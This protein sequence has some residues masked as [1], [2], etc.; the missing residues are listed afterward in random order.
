MIRMVKNKKGFTLMEMVVATALFLIAVTASIGIFLS[1]VKANNKVN[2]MQEV[3]NEARYVI[4]TIAKKIRLGTIYYDYYEEAY[5]VNFEN[6]VSILA[7]ADNADNV[8]Y[9]ALNGD[10]ES[11]GII[12]VD[13]S[14]SGIWSD[15]TS[16]DIIVD[17]LSFYLIPKLD[18]FSQS[19][20]SIQQPLVIIHLEA[21]YNNTDDTEG[22]IK[23]QTGV[24]SRQYKK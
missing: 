3:E 2:L 15:L 24:S 6:P 19:A 4:E 14:D 7:L 21:H 10:G 12:Q 20:E 11:V 13:F 18:P 8:S 16:G 23:I 22:K 9:F 1:A 5:G 17:E